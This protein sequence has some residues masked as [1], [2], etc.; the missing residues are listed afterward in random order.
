M[1]ALS[2]VS[3]PDPEAVLRPARPPGAQQSDRVRRIGVLIPYAE[4]DPEGQARAAALQQGLEKRGW[5]VGRNL[6]IDYR[7]SVDTVERNT[8]P[9]PKCWRRRL[10]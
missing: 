7:W 6:R 2:G 10:T 1:Q 8:P 4:S 3:E 9:S 5:M